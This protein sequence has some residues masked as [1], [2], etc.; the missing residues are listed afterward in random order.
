MK[1]HQVEYGQKFIHGIG[2]DKDNWEPNLSSLKKLSE[3]NIL[4]GNIILEN[5]D[6][7]NVKKFI[8]FSAKEWSLYNL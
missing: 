3:S 1:E 2:W 5:L 8:N 6:K 7:M 4:F